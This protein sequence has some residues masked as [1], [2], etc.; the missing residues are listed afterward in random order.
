MGLVA[1]Q[2]PACGASIEIPDGKEFGFCTYCGSKIYNEA[3]LN[4][5]IVEHSGTV[6]CKLPDFKITAEALTGY[7]G[8][9]KEVNIPDSVAIIKADAFKGLPVTAVRIPASVRELEP[10]AFNNCPSLEKIVLD[11]G[12]DAKGFDVGAFY[13]CPSIENITALGSLGQNINVF[14]VIKHGEVHFSSEEEYRGYKQRINGKN[15]DVDA[16][17]A[18]LEHLV[19]LKKNAGILGSNSFDKDICEL[20]ERLK[21]ERSYPK[22]FLDKE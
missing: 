21:D 2:C 14:Y 7:V 3:W 12:Y 9:S 4:R 11:D 17:K 22:L 19:R 18:R 16:L 5:T 20:S 8:Q 1:A 15:A 13:R 10:C 6:E